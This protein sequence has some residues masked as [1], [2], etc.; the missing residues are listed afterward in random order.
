[1]WVEVKG[2]N[3]AQLT[4]TVPSAF[5]TMPNTPGRTRAKRER[6]N[7]G[8]L[9]FLFLFWQ[10]LDVRPGCLRIFIL[11]RSTKVENDPPPK[12]IPVPATTALSGPGAE[13]VK[14]GQAHK[15]APPK[16]LR[17]SQSVNTTLLLY[18]ITENTTLTRI[19]ARTL[20]CNVQSVMHL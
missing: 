1:M 9:L 14:R 19:K 8:V 20:H 6:K 15:G 11:Q 10:S 7:H 2:K 17:V 12:C 3:L 4:T 5:S 18:K 16:V 13:A